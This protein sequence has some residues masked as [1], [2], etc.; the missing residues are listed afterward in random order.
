MVEQLL[1]RRV[2]N[3]TF[4]TTQL[5][6]LLTAPNKARLA[7]WTSLRS[8]VVEGEQIP[9]W[10]VRG[11]Y[12]LNLPQAAV[13]NGYAPAETTVCN[14]LRRYSHSPNYDCAMID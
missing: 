12:G 10:V 3:C 14:S 9:P 6:V 11:F 7:E 13:F 8:M 5:K 2:S 4:T 1:E